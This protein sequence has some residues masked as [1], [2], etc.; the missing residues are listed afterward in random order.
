M[1]DF[2]TRNW[3]GKSGKV[4]CNWQ[5]DAKEPDKKSKKFKEFT[6][7]VEETSNNEEV[8]IA[9]DTTSNDYSIY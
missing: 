1:G 7:I 2:N 9:G 6:P 3:L 8:N 4:S 5:Y